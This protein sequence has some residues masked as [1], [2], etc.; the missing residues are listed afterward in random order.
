MENYKS[1]IGEE[2]V[3][4]IKLLAEKL[5]GKSVIHVNSTSFGGGVAEI[6]HSMIPLMHDIGLKASWRIINGSLEF[7]NVTKK[8]HNALQGM[9]IQITSEEKK[10]YVEYNKMNAELIKPDADYIIIHDPQ[11]ASIIKF[12]SKKA[13]S[14]IHISEPTRP[15]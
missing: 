6:L 4:S 7:F 2:E 3:N 11:P 13:L 5:R 8:F 14:L 12:C 15:Y 1:I 10:I 9:D